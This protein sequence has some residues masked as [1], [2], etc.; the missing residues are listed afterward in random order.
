MPAYEHHFTPLVPPLGPGEHLRL[1]AKGEMKIDTGTGYQ[2]HVR[3]LCLDE[4]VRVIA[5]TVPEQII[6]HADFLNW[7][8]F[9]IENSVSALRLSVQ[10]NAMPFYNGDNFINVMYQSD[11][12][13]PAVPF[14]IGYSV[15]NEY[16]LDIGRVTGA[17]SAFCQKGVPR[18]A[19]LL[20][21]SQ[22]NFYPPQFKI[23]SLMRALELLYPE[24]KHRDEIYLLFEDSFAS[25][26]VSDKKLKNALPQIR[27]RCAHGKGRGDESP[28]VG[29]AYNEGKLSSLVSLL[30][31]MVMYGMGD[32]HNIKF[33]GIPENFEHLSRFLSEPSG[34]PSI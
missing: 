4:E 17:F 15:N 23:L 29:I 5:V 27:N 2:M 26:N 3:F 21:E 30:R 33:G 32:V 7:M 22:V 9:A 18:I 16:K 34:R 24:P 19:A 1:E 12:P 25:L 6:G 10:P 28:F 14:E 13:E 20:G 11:D 31:N 8:K